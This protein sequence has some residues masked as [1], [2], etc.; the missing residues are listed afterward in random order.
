KAW[1]GQGKTVAPRF[2]LS[3]HATAWSRAD[4]LPV[5][6]F[7]I[8]LDRHIREGYIVLVAHVPD[9]HGSVRCSTVAA[10]GIAFLPRSGYRK[11]SRG[12]GGHRLPKFTPGAAGCYAA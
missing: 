4:D 9:Q 6:A 2:E 11:C 1:F 12:A 7:T 3:M 5:F 8:D 10:P